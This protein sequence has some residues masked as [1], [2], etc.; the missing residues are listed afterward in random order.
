MRQSKR[1]Q[2]EHPTFPHDTSPSHVSLHAKTKI[3]E[4]DVDTTNDAAPSFLDGNN[5]PNPYLSVI[6]PLLL[7]YVSNQW[8]RSSIYYLVNF[9]DSASVTAQNAMNVD[10][11]FSQAQYGA[12]ASVA[13]TALFAFASLAAGNLA[14]RSDRKLLTAVSAVAWSVATVATASASSY[15]EVV[16]ARIFMGLACAFS[17][18]S[19]YTLIRDLVPSDR[20]A[21]ASSIYGSGVYL[22]GALASLSILLDNSLGWR[23]ALGTI[24]AYGL[25]S[26]GLSYAVLPPDP[27]RNI[28]DDAG[29]SSKEKDQT[30]VDNESSE[31][32]SSIITDATDV[33]STSRVRWLFAASFF[34][35]CSGLCIG[36][37][38]APYFRLAFPDDS[39]SYAVVNAFIVSLCGV[40]SG[41]VGGWSADKAGAAAVRAGSNEN[42]GRLAVPIVGSLL[43]VPTWWF[44]VH[45]P[46]FE[47]AMFWLGME[48]LVAE[49]WFGPVVA[50]LQS[51]VGSGL[52][53][54]A[55]GMFTLCGAVGNFAP[56]ALGILYG[57]AAATTV[58]DGSALSSLLGTGVCAGY[59]LSA[60]CFTISAQASNEGTGKASLLEKQS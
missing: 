13:F 54:T 43:A 26:A 12:L 31:Q 16:A 39:T 23:G 50:V 49:C 5:G 42:A 10:I 36:V 44:A 34:R 15:G 45:S 30:T 51:S 57:Q 47:L 2:A 55:Q 25:V 11:G 8:S 14:D 19:A 32:L 6:F 4:V 29:Q 38:A 35:F 27:K 3:K 37:W 28:V 59:I 58:E 7:V 52:G 22:G 24:A 40:T 46:T 18:P 53:G 17:T 60:V 41:V 20:A 56:S 21:L 1:K 33:L 48:Y 9:S